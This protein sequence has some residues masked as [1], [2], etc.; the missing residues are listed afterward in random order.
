MEFDFEMGRGRAGRERDDS[1]PMRLLLIGDFSGR[2]VAER[3]PLSSRPTH[4]VDIDTLDVAMQRL[5]PRVRLPVGEIAF[6]RIDDFHPDALFNRLELFQTLR[7]A[8][9]N[10]PTDNTAV[11]S[12]DLGRLL[13]KPAESPATPVAA[14]ASAAGGI[15][16]L[17]RNIVA[18]HIIK[19]TTA[20]TKSYLAAVDAAIAAEMRTLLHDPAFQALESAW[21][22]VQW[23]TSSLELDGPLQLHLFDATREE[24][25][26]DVIAAGGKLAQTGIYR[27]LVDRWRNVPGGEGWSVLATLFEFGPSTAD[28]GLVAAMGLIA[29]NA[30]GPLLAGADPSLAGDGALADESAKTDWFALRR[31]EAATWIGLAAPRV[32]LRMPYGKASDPIEGF[33]FDECVGEPAPN[34]LLWANG[35]V[36]AMLLIGRAFNER[37]WDMEPGDEREIGDLPAYT[38]TRDGERQMQPCGERVLTESQIDS[39]IKGGLIPIASRRDRNA[40]VA[41]RFQ[42]IADP[43]APLAW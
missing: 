12:D 26:A 23:L 37:G 42:S 7:Q 41:I 32:L 25:V 18:P 1:R 35:S 6:H 22:G 10:P 2:P 38:F 14:G 16:A 43:P 5:G 19:D 31:S 17:I 20:G 27:A 13:G 8:R 21:R 36:A 33:A 9:T 24:L 29:S 3:P 15:D 11:G 28:V 30:G 34:E 40:V 4:Q 39:M